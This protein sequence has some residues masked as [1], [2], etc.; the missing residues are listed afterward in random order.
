VIGGLV[1]IL[2]TSPKLRYSSCSPLAMQWARSA[3]APFSSAAS[4]AHWL[5]P[6]SPAPQGGAVPRARPPPEVDPDSVS[7]IAEEKPASCCCRA[8]VAGESRRIRLREHRAIA[9]EAG[10]GV[11]CDVREGERQGCR[12]GRPAGRN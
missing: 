5:P 11:L 4:A 3:S 1:E 12:E 6:S 10:F 2:E 8:G 7:R 9:A